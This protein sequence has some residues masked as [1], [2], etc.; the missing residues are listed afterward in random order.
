MRLRPVSSGSSTSSST[1]LRHHLLHRRL[2]VPLRSAYRYEPLPSARA[3]RLLE[4]Q[5]TDANG[6]LHCSLKSFED[7]T[8][9]P[10]YHALSYT[11]GFPLTS[12]SKTPPPSQ[13]SGGH[14]TA[15]LPRGNSARKIAAAAAQAAADRQQQQHHDG[16]E[17]RHDGDDHSNTTTATVLHAHSHSFP[18][19]CD[20]RTFLVTANLHD[21][22]H[23]LK[24]ATSTTARHFWIDAICVDQA[25]LSERNAQVAMMAETF[26]TAESVIVWLGAEDQF[27]SDAIALVKTI[28]ASVP[29]SLWEDISYTDFFDPEWWHLKA[30]ILKGSAAA[31]ALAPAKWLALIAFLNRPWFRRAWVVQELALARSA[32]LVCGYQSISWQALDHTLRFILATRWYHHLSTDKMRH[33]AG[34]VNSTAIDRDFLQSGTKVGMGSINLSRTRRDIMTA[35]EDRPSAFLGRLIQM[36]RST[37]ATDPRDKIYAFLGLADRP[38]LPERTEPIKADYSLPVQR[39]YT[40]VTA[41]LMLSQGNLQ[42]LSH[43]QDASRNKIRSGLPSWVPDYSAT[44]EPYPLSLRGGKYRWSACG[45][46]TWRPDPEGMKEGLLLVQGYRVGTIAETAAMPDEAVGGKAAYWAGIIDVALGMDDYYPFRSRNAPPQTRVEALWRTL[47]TNTYSRTHPAPAACGMLFIDYVL[48]LQIRKHL[49][50]PWS[51]V[52]F[53]PPPSQHSSGSDKQQQQQKADSA[54]A[55]HKLIE[56]EPAD[57]PYGKHFFRERMSTITERIF[58]GAYKTVQLAQLQHDFDIASGDMRRV[59]RTD[60]GLLGTGPRSLRKGDEIW[61]LGGARVPMVLR[62]LGAGVGGGNRYHALV[63]EC[64]IHGI[65]HSMQTSDEDGRRLVDVILE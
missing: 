62:R 50:V 7:Q 54:P 1:V 2:P 21:A 16:V 53:H 25:N 64:Y 38:V 8:K 51:S 28:A 31:A 61:V 45:S 22:L 36:H 49:L 20:G 44:L 42:Q 30:G 40:S 12:F 52:D 17:R 6:T 9:A 32:L 48:N 5:Y 56:A 57:S 29:K 58:Q 26:G 59:F 65:M 4:L 37:Q 15:R 43:V 41:S 33:M 3:I 19:A 39:V 14:N 24:D 23:M 13:R 60:G 63:G 18:I 55:W 35:R 10:P 47:I 27:T 46:L 34:V 11:W